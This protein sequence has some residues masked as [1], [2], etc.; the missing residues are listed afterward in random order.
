MSGTSPH[1]VHPR[2][3]DLA[4]R[5]R[6]EFTEMP[7]LH[8]TFEQL[9]R[10]WHLSDADCQTVLNVLLD[11]GILARD[12]RDLFCLQHTRVAWPSLPPREPRHGS[13]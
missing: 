3:D 5:I 8:L 1:P 11:E 4:W 2:L 9:R 6:S 10:L 7:G 12:E 13:A